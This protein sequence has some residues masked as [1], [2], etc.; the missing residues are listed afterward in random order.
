MCVHKGILIKIDHG[1]LCL[2]R[3]NEKR[4]S[5]ILLVRKPLEQQSHAESGIVEY[6]NIKIDLVGKCGDVN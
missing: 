2:C 5:G 1:I 4:Q 6:H 3:K